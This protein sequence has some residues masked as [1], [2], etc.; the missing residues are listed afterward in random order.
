MDV[1]TSADAPSAAT[2]ADDVG[3][4]PVDLAAIAS[5]L[6]QVEAALI[7]LDDGAYGRCGACGQPIDDGLL[8]ARPTAS[9]CSAHVAL[10]D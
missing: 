2:T 4:P 6:S 9:S 10:G 3:P 5:E 1:P 7:R 8:A